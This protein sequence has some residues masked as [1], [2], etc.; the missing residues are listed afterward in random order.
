[1]RSLFDPVVEKI[2][3]LM[4]NQVEQ[5]KLERKR[6]IDTV[7]LVGGFGSS[8]YID[9]KLE[10]WC[11]KRSMRLTTP[12]SGAWSAV[13][14]GAVLRGLE[15]S[16]TTQRK[17]RRH[18]GYQHSRTYDPVAH[19]GYDKSKRELYV[20]PFKG[21]CLTGFMSWN[22]G[23]NDVLDKT[24]EINSYFEITTYSLDLIEGEIDLLACSLD[25]APDTNESERIEKVGSVEYG[26]EDLDPLGSF[27]RTTMED[28][29]KAYEL[30]FTLN[31][32]MS[33]EAGLLAFRVL[34]EGEDVGKAKL[35][36]S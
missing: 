9:E 12:W 23:K 10:A 8:G 29:I 5:T 19:R 36:F 26:V 22:I 32:R 24:T 21:Q 30:R 14:V 6:N 1:M 7:V 11:A 2:E 28:G 3:Q 25:D 33:D 16:I 13:V 31:I 17:C 27:K 34:H 4:S 35:A 20:D 15:G 18:Y